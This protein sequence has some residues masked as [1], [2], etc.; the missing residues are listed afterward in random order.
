MKSKNFIVE[1]VPLGEDVGINA[2]WR[3]WLMSVV[4]GH[5]YDPDQVVVTSPPSSPLLVTVMELFQ[6]VMSMEMDL[7][8]ITEINKTRLPLK[9]QIWYSSSLLYMS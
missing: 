7:G 5:W 1:A 9:V 4:T 3:G 8:N 2:V 6:R